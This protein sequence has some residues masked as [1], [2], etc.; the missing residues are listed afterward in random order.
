MSKNVDQL[1]SELVDNEIA[2]EDI[3]TLLKSLKQDANCSETWSRYNMIGDAMKRD[4]PH[5][6]KH[7]LVSRVS[8]ALESEPTIFI[9]NI[10]EQQNPKPQI[11]DDQDAYIV[12]RPVAR[13]TAGRKRFF[14]PAVGLAT[15]ATVAMVSVF[16]YQTW[17][18]PIVNDP[19]LT[20]KQVA[21]QSNAMPVNAPVK[22]FPNTQV[23]QVI[24]VDSQQLLGT[25]SQSVAKSNPIESGEWER[26]QANT[27]QGAIVA[28]Q[29]NQAPSVSN[30]MA[31]IVSFGAE[32]NKK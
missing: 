22:V 32:E 24:I 28:E 29:S 4:L 31:R 26:L 20:V 1:I 21:G 30:P 5:Q 8:K 9:P 13:S 2:R 25:Q 3:D 19:M 23:P 16:A 12:A 6:M 17:F 10:E 15:A 27:P 11:Q 14:D 18:S 7:D